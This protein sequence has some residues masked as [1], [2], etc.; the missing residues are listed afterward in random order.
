M[1]TDRDAQLALDNRQPPDH[2]RE[3]QKP[4]ET[5]PLEVL[6]DEGWTPA[7]E[8]P[9]TDRVVQVA[10]DDGS[11][12]PTS[13]AFYDG[14]AVIPQ[15]PRKYWWTHPGLSILPEGSVIAWRDKPLEGPEL[16]DALV[17]ALEERRKHER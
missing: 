1:T 5:D 13:L 10:W 16:M 14:K 3:V 9:D 15:E 4:M 11:Y 17:E 2:W 12:T 6:I 8:P 7:S